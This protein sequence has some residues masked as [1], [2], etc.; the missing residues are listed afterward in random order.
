MIRGFPRFP[1]LQEISLRAIHPS[2]SD[3]AVLSHILHRNMSGITTRNQI[4]RPNLAGASSL[5]DPSQQDHLKLLAQNLRAGSHVD[6]APQIANLRGMANSESMDDLF[7]REA[8][9]LHAFQKGWVSRRTL[10]AYLCTEAPRVLVEYRGAILKLLKDQK[11]ML[12]DDLVRG[13]GANP[14]QDSYD[15][16]MSFATDES[17]QTEI[18]TRTAA[19]RELKVF[20]YEPS[21][22]WFERWIESGPADMKHAALETLGCMDDGLERIM[23]LLRS[24]QDNPYSTDASSLL[25]GLRQNPSPLF[26]VTLR[27][28]MKPYLSSPFFVQK[29]AA[30]EVLSRGQPGETALPVL[31]RLARQDPHHSIKSLA[32]KKIGEFLPHP[33]AAN[34]VKRSLETLQGD[35]QGTLIEVAGKLQDPSTIPRLYQLSLIGGHHKEMAVEAL[36]K[37]P[38]NNTGSI[39]QK[40]I[41]SKDGLIREAALRSLKHQKN[42]TSSEPFIHHALKERFMGAQLALMELIADIGDEHALDYLAEIPDKEFHLLNWIHILPKISEKQPIILESTLGLLATMSRHPKMPVRR[43]VAKALAHLDQQESGQILASLLRDPAMMVQEAALSS[44][45]TYPTK[46]RT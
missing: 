16:L 42:E 3:E 31:I 23:N 40:L 4:L 19:I 17:Q 12:P 9:V 10:P 1:S 32:I 43:A 41:T 45:A 36:G 44:L 46:E 26:S 27:N 28:L 39:L 7:F 20:S 2:S 21:K 34:F 37:F 15:A 8:T 14:C 35:G 29:A 38:G 5:T 33:D 13:F 6:L 11:L 25:Q 24:W 18:M 30:I 22:D